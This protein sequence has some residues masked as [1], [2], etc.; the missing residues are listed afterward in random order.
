MPG[1]C[2]KRL[3][4][5]GGQVEAPGHTQIRDLGCH[6]GS[7]EDIVGREISV[8]DGRNLAAHVEVAQA[9]NHVMKDGIADILWENTVTRMGARTPC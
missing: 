1:V 5:S 4:C 3:T 2:V 6:V 9:Q 8:N 7:E